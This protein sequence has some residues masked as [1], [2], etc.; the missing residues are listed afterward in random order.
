MKGSA[1]GMMVGYEDGM[2]EYAEFVIALE[3]DVKY[4]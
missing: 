4:K 3:F 1:S 2:M